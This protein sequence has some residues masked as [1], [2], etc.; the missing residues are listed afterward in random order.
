MISVGKHIHTYVVTHEN[1]V[2]ICSKHAF[3]C[4]PALYVTGQ[5]KALWLAQRLTRA[6]LWP[7]QAASMRV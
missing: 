3:V 6:N 4:A 1:S 7:I 5:E 2:N